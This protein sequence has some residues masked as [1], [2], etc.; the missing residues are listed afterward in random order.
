MSD[1]LNIKKLKK[2]VFDTLRWKKL[3]LPTRFPRSCLFLGM[4]FAVFSQG[5]IFKALRYILILKKL[6]TVALSDVLSVETQLK[7]L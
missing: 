7:L 3:T 1:K 5:L 2:P 4:D 6:S